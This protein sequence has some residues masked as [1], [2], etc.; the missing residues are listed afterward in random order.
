MG[1]KLRRQLRDAFGSEIVGLPRLV[2]LEIADEV[3]DD[4]RTGRVDLHDLARWTSAANPSVVRDMFGR[5][6]AAGWELRVPIGRG[7]GG[8]LL[9]AV[10]GI[11]LT[12]RVP[13]R[14]YEPIIE[15]E[16]RFGAPSRAD[17]VRLLVLRDGP[18][19]RGCGLLPDD[20]TDL[21]IDHYMPRALGGGNET[22]NLQ[23]LCVPC[24]RR[25]R[26]KH[27]DVWRALV[28]RGGSR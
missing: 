28:Q 20:P 24:N 6:A 22:D 15:P 13:E 10:P 7:G 16:A 14:R 8:R 4:T 3:D 9:Y 23:L 12:F 26:D 19:C 2:A 21:E 5:L 27:P 11:P 18:A 17:L 1:Y 25:K